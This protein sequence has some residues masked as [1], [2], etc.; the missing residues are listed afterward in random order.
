[1]LI[2]EFN[3]FSVVF[4]LRSILGSTLVWCRLV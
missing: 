1:M 3:L 4:V 2:C